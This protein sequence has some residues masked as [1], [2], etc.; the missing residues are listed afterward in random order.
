M[1]EQ[2]VFLILIRGYVVMAYAY[3]TWTEEETF[4][5]YICDFLDKDLT[6]L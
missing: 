5:S 2:D 1:N 4:E 6:Y 3:L